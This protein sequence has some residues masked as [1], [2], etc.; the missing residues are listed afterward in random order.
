MTVLL[1]RSKLVVLAVAAALLASV[2]VAPRALAPAA[3]AKSAAAAQ[4]LQK[5]ISHGLLAPGHRVPGAHEKRVGSGVTDVSYTNWSGYADD[6]SSGT[7]YTRVSGSWVEPSITCPADENRVAVFWIGFDGFDNSTVEQDGTLA[8]CFEGTPYHYTWWEMY[9]TN[10]IQ[11][12]GDTVAAGDH[13]AAL[14]SYSTYHKYT[15]KITDSTNTA[16][17]FT[18]VQKCAVGL[19]CANASA[20]WIAETPGYDRGLS[21]LPDFGTW[22]VTAAKATGSGTAGVISSFPDDRITIE[23]SFGENLAN[24]SVLT[25]PGNSFHVTWAYAW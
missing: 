14:A 9:P 24:P 6:E 13:I 5:F 2:V 17:S 19:T 7:T 1:S 16:N 8:E 3:A 20:E 18:E 10:D 11:I 22:R 12:V 23:G 15:L 21:P 25:A 4:W